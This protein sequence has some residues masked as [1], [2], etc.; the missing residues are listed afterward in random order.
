M[1]HGF[2]IMRVPNPTDDI[3]AIWQYIQT[4]KIPEYGGFSNWM[5]WMGWNGV[6]YKIYKEKGLLPEDLSDLHSCLAACL[7]RN[8]VSKDFV[9]GD[10]RQA[11]PRAIIKK[12]ANH[13]HL[14]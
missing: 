6:Q 1:G 14:Q 5:E 12:I 8:I 11:F 4:I 7:E 2:R 9:D 13:P 3:T 10:E